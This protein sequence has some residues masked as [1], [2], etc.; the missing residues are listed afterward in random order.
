[1]IAN[2]AMAIIL[3]IINVILFRFWTIKMWKPPMNSYLFFKYINEKKGLGIKNFMSI[4]LIVNQFVPLDLLVVLEISK[5]VY[6]G[7]MEDDV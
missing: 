1:L 6:T 7:V 4:Y 5:L 2:L 3:A